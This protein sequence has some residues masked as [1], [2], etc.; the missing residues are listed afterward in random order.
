MVSHVVLIRFRI[1]QIKDLDRFLRWQRLDR[2][3]RKF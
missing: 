3:E 2:G 1:G